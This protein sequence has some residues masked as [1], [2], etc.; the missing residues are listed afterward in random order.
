MKK[1]LLTLVTLL[2]VFQATPS[3]AQDISF[4]IKVGRLDK[5][6]FKPVDQVVT[7]VPFAIQITAYKGDRPYRYFQNALQ[8]EG[9]Y[10]TNSDNELIPLGST[11][12]FDQGICLI[13]K[14]Y[15]EGKFHIYHQGE[16]TTWTTDRTILPGWT[17]L[18]P[19]LL[20]ILLAFLIREVV[21]AL[22]V[23]IWLGASLLAGYNPL[24]GAMNTVDT[25]IIASIADTS[26]AQIIFFSLMLGGMVGIIGRS[27]GMHALVQAFSHYAQSRRATQTTTVGMGLLIFFD[28]YANTLLVGNTMRP[29]TDKAQISREKLAYMVDS[30]AAPVAGLALISTWIGTE[31]SYFQDYINVYPEG[32]EQVPTAIYLFGMSVPFRFYSIFALFFVF[33]VAWSLRDY[34]PM[35]LAE[36]RS[37]HHGKVL[38]HGAVPLADGSIDEFTAD[39]DQKVYW[40][41]AVVPIVA[42]I[43]AICGG[44]YYTGYTS[45]SAEA[46]E[47]AS[48][49]QI[50]GQSDS[51]KALC[52]GAT[53]GVVVAGVM[54]L[55]QGVLDFREVVRSW[56]TGVKSMTFAMIVLVLA[57][58]LGGLCE[59]Q[60]YTGPFLSEMIQGRIALWLLP[61]IIFIL[62]GVTAFA[63]GTS[64]GTMGILLPLAIPLSIDLVTAEGF[65]TAGVANPYGWSIIMACASAVLAGACFGDHCSPISDTTVMS[66]MASGCD[67][68]DHVRTQ[69]PYA[70]TTAGVAIA[71]GYI[72]IGFGM[73]PYYSLLIGVVALTAILFVVGKK[74]EDLGPPPEDEIR[75][76]G[77]GEVEKNEA[78]SDDKEGEKD[79]VSPGEAGEN[80]EDE[81]DKEKA[82]EKGEG[83]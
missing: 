6:K 76:E 16:K 51:Y 29:L 60:L 58:T 68:L 64:W 21:L 65:V 73:S 62:A 79:Q 56:L 40:Y 41:H 72:P 47:V 37:L 77:P 14:V 24:L 38:R 10:K 52:W 13:K 63:T 26:H 20:A 82:D 23:G 50:I 27:G 32:W 4:Q 80:V 54:V 66:S 83:K 7:D 39:P 69:L 22:F 70:M 2:L 35:L 45:F 36:R 31:M 53:L 5:G 15:L 49:W 30:T 74:A 44:L 1:A 81:E 17:S 19:P 75:G 43:F 55:V 9:V 25:H 78:S 28:D 59:K 11:G 71:A 48:F 46:L 18:L 8:I 67:H 3:W 42:T 57:W 33:L 61:T 12:T 34:G